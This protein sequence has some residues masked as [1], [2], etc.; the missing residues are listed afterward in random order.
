[1]TQKKNRKLAEQASR[2]ARGYKIVSPDLD[3]RLALYIKC[4]EWNV[5]PEKGGWYDQS[6]EVTEAFDIIAYQIHEEERKEQKKQEL[7][8][9]SQ[10]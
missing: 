7:R 2:Y 6:P 3:E 9:R 10:R 5:L 8:A 4:K 1:M